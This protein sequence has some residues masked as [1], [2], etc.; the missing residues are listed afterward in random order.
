M[1]TL[2]IGSAVY[3]A[4]AGFAQAQVSGQ[5]TVHLNVGPGKKFARLADAV[6]VANA[7]SSPDKY[8]VVTLAPQTYVNDFAEI[9][10]PMDD[11]GC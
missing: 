3:L 2:L 4:L 9:H 10:R 5:T 11:W 7:D 6:A 1:R 8:Y